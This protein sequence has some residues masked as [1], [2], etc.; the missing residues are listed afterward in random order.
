MGA[1]DK[2][3][4]SIAECRIF[5]R[6]LARGERSRPSGPWAAAA[7]RVTGPPFSWVAVVCTLAYVACYLAYP[8][9]PGNSPHVEGWWGWFDQGQYLK[10]VKALVL[11]FRQFVPDVSHRSQGRG[12]LRGNEVSNPVH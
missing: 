4:G 3:R 7:Y 9:L 8:S 5:S 2:H 10:S 11:R 1:I 12:Q 6:S